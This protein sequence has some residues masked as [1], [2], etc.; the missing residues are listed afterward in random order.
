MNFS[1]KQTEIEL[2]GGYFDGM[3]HK[4]LGDL[5]PSWRMPGPDM[6]TIDYTRTSERS[7]SGHIKYIFE[8][9]TSRRR[10]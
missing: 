10:E 7:A 9:V 1:L 5:P 6:S 4:V 3:T 2:F 8:G